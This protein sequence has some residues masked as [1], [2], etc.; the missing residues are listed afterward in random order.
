MGGGK[1]GRRRGG[2][3]GFVESQE[4]VVATYLTQQLIDNITAPR[5]RLLASQEKQEKNRPRRG[6]YAAGLVFPFG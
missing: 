2:E 1:G 6:C 3:N 5:L 4:R